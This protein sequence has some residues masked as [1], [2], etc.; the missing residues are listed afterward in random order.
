MFR[1]QSSSRNFKGGSWDLRK[2]D[3]RKLQATI[4]FPDRR[5]NDR[6]AGS[7]GDDQALGMDGLQWV[8]K[9]ALDE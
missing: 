6:R 2:I 8:T 5:A 3:R 7:Q 1:E 4:E 9:S